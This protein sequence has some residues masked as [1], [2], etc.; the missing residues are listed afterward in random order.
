MGS[1]QCSLVLNLN[2]PGYQ[3]ILPAVRADDPLIDFLDRTQWIVDVDQYRADPEAYEEFE[4][5]AWLIAHPRAS[6]IV[7]LFHGNSLRAFLVLASR[8]TNRP[9]DWETIDL[10]KAV[11]RQAASY[12]A[13]EEAAN[14]LSDARRLDSFNRRFAF[15]VHDIKNLVS[16]MSLMLQNA[17]RYG[18]DPEFQKD[19]LA[20][21][22]NTVIRM[23]SLL[24][25]FKAEN[26][27]ETAEPRP[28]Q[29]KPL[30]SRVGENWRRQMP[31][32]D[33]DLEGEDMCVIA[34]DGSLASVFDHLL[35]NAVEACGAEGHVVLRLRRQG[36]DA[37]VEVEDD[38]PGMDAAFIRDHLFR[39][40]RTE[41]A[42]GYGLGAYQ[43][44]ELVREIGGRL[45]VES[46]PG[47]GTMMRV[48]IPLAE[49]PQL[50]AMNGT[51]GASN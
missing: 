2:E 51:R 29:L 43:T 4:A 6:V 37:V 7:P 25:Q 30:V 35:Q 50:V 20:T 15:V 18:D 45:D 22:G 26:T 33:I 49:S 39:P 31:N 40:L 13:E 14:A 48:V 34:N 28:L 10:L 3:E 12:L 44:R 27:E 21:V 19:M 9:L 36:N 16:Q 17:E 5:P 23:T 46:V 1:D 42:D 32:L 8:R 47:K 41:K 11:A 38:G 24:E